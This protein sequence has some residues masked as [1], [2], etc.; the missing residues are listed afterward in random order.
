VKPVYFF[1]A[2]NNRDQARMAST[3][4]GSVEVVPWG[5]DAVAETRRNAA[6][7][8]I[9]VPVSTLPAL[10][11]YRPE[12]TREALDEQGEPVLDE[13]QQPVTETIP[14]HYE[15]LT[16]DDPRIPTPWDWRNLPGGLG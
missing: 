16:A 8:A 1:F 5:W 15:V 13:N 2:P 14:A 12:V 3:A 9:G 7:A 4:P 6:L 10:A 11:L